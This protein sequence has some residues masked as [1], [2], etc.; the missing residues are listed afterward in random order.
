ML[1]FFKC[2]LPVSKIFKYPSSTATRSLLRWRNHFT[3]MAV[4]GVDE[5]KKKIET[6]K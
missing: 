3:I 4:G 2:G 5:S 1:G 6:G